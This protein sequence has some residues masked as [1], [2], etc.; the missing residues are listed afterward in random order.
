M[1][2]GE[3]KGTVVL[4]G[5]RD[6]GQEERWVMQG[7]AKEK[8][9]PVLMAMYVRHDSVVTADGYQIHAIPRPAN[10]DEHEGELLRPVGRIPR[11]V[12]KGQ[13][14]WSVEAEKL[15]GTFPDITQ[16]LPNDGQEPIAVFKLDGDR[17]A[18]AC[19]GGGVVTFKVYSPTAPVE[20]FMRKHD[21]DDDLRQ[22]YTLIMPMIPYT[23]DDTERPGWRPQPEPKAAEAEAEIVEIVQETISLS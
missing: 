3:A 23:K 2:Y 18:K 5:S 17:L 21:K 9:R 7:A 15:Y 8:S 1:S 4:R 16:I 13:E 10:L 19:K 20:L 11:S 22:R 6:E 14:E 12:P